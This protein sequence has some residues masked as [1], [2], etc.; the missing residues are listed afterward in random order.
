MKFSNYIW[1]LYLLV[2]PFYFFKEGNPQLADIFGVLF[3]ALSSK[4]VITSISSN[5]FTKNLFLFVIYTIFVNAIWM[6]IVG[7][8]KILRSSVYYLYSFLLMLAVFSRL[9]DKSFLRITYRALTLIVILHMVVY[10]FMQ[11][12][13]VRAEMFFNNPN[14]LALWCTC[15]L[16]IIYTLTRLLNL[17]AIYVVVPALIITVFVITS[18][19]RAALLS[20]LGFWLYFII[21]SRK[22][23]VAVGI[24]G[25]LAFL[26]ISY[27]F[28]IDVN[29]IAAVEYNMNRFSSNSFSSTQSF[30]GRGYDRII[31]YPQYLG[32]G[33][34]EG[35]YWRFDE[36]IELHSN[37]LN[38]LF[39]YGIVGLLI[40]LGAFASFIRNIS[41]EVITLLFVLVFFGI[42][43]MT[44]RIPMYWI[45]LLFVV[46]LHEENN[47][48]N[49]LLSTD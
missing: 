25:L 30:G 8:F 27:N 23:F 33:A 43:H 6:L 32:F 18:A 46:Y 34:G 45:A 2:F 39:S 38:I 40:Y 4:N 42:V 3:I 7:D 48:K 22:H 16:V 5:R 35:E 20:C 21:K 13:G 44:M 15:L 26:F 1:A 17:N 31:Q 49:D 29:N 24:L 37:L 47:R 12:Q 10:P 11:P 36:S 19:S 28:T 14:Q 9:K 41:K